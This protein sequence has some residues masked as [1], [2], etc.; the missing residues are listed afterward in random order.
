MVTFI[1]ITNS[2][3]KFI[4]LTLQQLIYIMCNALWVLEK[5]IINKKYYYYF[6]D[7]CGFTGILLWTEIKD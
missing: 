1:K 4:S 7:K 2:S 3:D 6:Y 5:H